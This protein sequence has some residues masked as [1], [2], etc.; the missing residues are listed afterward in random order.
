MK[1]KLIILTGPTGVGKTKSSIHLANSLDTEIIS[2]DSFQVYKGMDIGTDK[3]KYEDMNGV[4]HHNIDIINPDDEYNVAIYQQETIKLIKSINM[5]GRVPLLVGGTG[6]YLHSILYD[7]DFDG[8]KTNSELRKKINEKVKNF[9]LGYIYDKL[10]KV[11]PNTKNLLDSK[12]THRVVR[13][14]EVYVRTGKTPS[15]TLNDFRPRE[16]KY[17]VLYI[18]LNKNRESLYT[19]INKRVDQMFH[20][21]LKEE[22]DSLI[23]NGYSFDLRS[24]EA[25]GYKEFKE[26]Y[27]G[28]KSLDQVREKIKQHSR[29]YAKRQLTWF[30]REEHATWINV[31][32]F[33]NQDR[34]N[35]YLIQISTEFIEST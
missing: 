16:L 35:E 25:I 30:R 9:G 33:S 8:K 27:N 32:D 17:D 34:L 2:A 3:I 6:L 20:E 22:I 26:Y 1:E 14:Y 10:V 21:G 5:S 23:A 19:D 31:D 29:N 18:V 11:D 13:S 4:K 15:Q 28:E 24:F 7:L 12:N